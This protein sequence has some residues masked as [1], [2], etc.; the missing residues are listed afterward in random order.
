M[1]GSN[2]HPLEISLELWQKSG[3]YE[4]YRHYPGNYGSHMGITGIKQ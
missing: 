3:N 4:S 2:G 1:T